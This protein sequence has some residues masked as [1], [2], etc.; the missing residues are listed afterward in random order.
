M[1]R[2]HIFVLDSGMCRSNAAFIAK[3]MSHDLQTSGKTIFV[4]DSGMCRSNAAFIVKLMS[5][6]S[7]TSGKTTY[8]CTRQ[9]YV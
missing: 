3:L 8:F 6:D 4:L 5:H 7:Q 1:G 2:Q 9:W